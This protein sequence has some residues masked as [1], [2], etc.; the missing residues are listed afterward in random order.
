MASIDAPLVT[1][2]QL[3]VPMEEFKYVS[4]HLDLYFNL[5]PLEMDLVL[6][7]F[8]NLEEYPVYRKNLKLVQRLLLFDLERNSWRTGWHCLQKITLWFQL[9][10]I[11]VTSNV[12]RYYYGKLWRPNIK[13]FGGS[14]NS[15]SLNWNIDLRICK[16]MDWRSIYYFCSSNSCRS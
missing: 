1:K 6:K 8:F 16:R 11:E 7:H 12:I 4:S 9:T 15:I 5:I 2:P 10:N 13:N 3:S 14:C